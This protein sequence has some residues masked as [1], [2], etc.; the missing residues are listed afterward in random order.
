MTKLFRY[1]L[2]NNILFA[3]KSCALCYYI[4]VADDDDGD[5]IY[6]CDCRFYSLP[7]LWF[8][9]LTIHLNFGHRVV[10]EWVGN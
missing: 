7:Q 3:E 4:H 1:G 8:V 9:T 10:H 5:E 2:S 6:Y